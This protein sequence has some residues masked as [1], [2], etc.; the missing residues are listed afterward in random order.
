VYYHPKNT[1]LAGLLGEFNHIKSKI[2]ENT[3]QLKSKKN[4]LVRPN[5]I[6]VCNQIN[7]ADIKLKILDCIYN[8]KCFEVKA[9]HASQQIITIYSFEELQVGHENY[10]EIEH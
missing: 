1:R 4:I 9:I 6:K 8:G 7:C 3:S 5:K 10:F 2:L